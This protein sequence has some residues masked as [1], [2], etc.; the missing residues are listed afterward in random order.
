MALDTNRMNYNVLY[1]TLDEKEMY[2]TIGVTYIAKYV[3]SKRYLFKKE[4]I[5][6]VYH[7]NTDG[8][9]DS[10][11]YGKLLNKGPQCGVEY[12]LMGWNINK[13]TNLE[14][15]GLKK[16]A[17]EMTFSWETLTHATPIENNLLNIEISNFFDNPIEYFKKSEPIEKRIIEKVR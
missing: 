7:F 13:D 8:I 16:T 12:T 17:K 4:P 5:I 9:I 10:V 1:K 15:V 6:Y 11:S 3:D 2:F 14:K